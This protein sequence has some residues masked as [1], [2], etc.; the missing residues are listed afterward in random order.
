MTAALK[1]PG[2]PRKM[3]ADPGHFQ[4]GAL[5]GKTIYFSRIASTSPA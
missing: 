4:R 3:A 1:W 2:C 5:V